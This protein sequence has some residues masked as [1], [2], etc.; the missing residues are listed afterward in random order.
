MK[1]IVAIYRDF[2]KDGKIHISSYIFGLCIS[3]FCVTGLVYTIFDGYTNLFLFVCGLIASVLLTPLAY[4]ALENSISVKMSSNQIVSK[5]G[6]VVIGAVSFSALLL[7]QIPIF[8]AFYPGVCTY[9]LTTQLQQ[10]ETGIFRSNHPLLHTLFVG[11]LKNSFRNE[12]MGMAI[13]NII[14]MIVM[15]S[16]LAA[17]VVFVY[18]QS[19]N[20]H[21]SV[22]LIVFYA[23][24]PVIHFMAISS[25]KDILFSCFFVLSILSFYQI[26]NDDKNGVLSA[27]VYILSTILMLLFRN[28]AIYSY[29]PAALVLLVIASKSSISLSRKRIAIVGVLLSLCMFCVCNKTLNILLDSENTSI[30]EAMSVP[31]QSDARIYNYA[32]KEYESEIVKK[33]IDEPERYKSYISDPIKEQL[34]FD[35][36]D[37]KCKHFLLD[38]FLLALRNPIISIDSFLYTNQ[39]YWDI[40][41]APYQRDYSFL[42]PLEEKYRGGTFLESRNIWLKDICQKY[43][44]KQDEICRNPLIVFVNNGLYVWLTLYCLYRGVRKKKSAVV[45]ITILPCMYL[46]TLL[47]GPASITRYALVFFMI[48]PFAISTTIFDSGVCLCEE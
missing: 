42:A 14:Q 48:A 25:T 30:K 29:I 34:D 11:V 31:A 24:N 22:V 26:F 9:D 36:F 20:K 27:I 4:W 35:V 16:V 45:C 41:R 37:S 2:R 6:I 12:N 18:K 47:L 5:K 44:N 43:L 8:M 17:I 3:F 21:I 19:S 13:S 15:D 39:G 23:L 7:C 28:N 46:M 38:S 40:F 10:Y 33:Y 32:G 1:K